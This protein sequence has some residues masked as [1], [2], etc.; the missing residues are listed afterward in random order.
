MRHYTLRFMPDDRVIQIHH[1]A[2][3]LEAAGQA[4]IV[5]TTPCG[6]M[7]RC[8]K[9]RVQL[10]R[11]GKEL[12]AC[13]T[14][15]QSDLEV[16]VPEK[17]RFLRQQILQHG[18]GRHFPLDPPVQKVFVPGRW[19]GIDAFCQK[20][21]DRGDICLHLDGP[22]EMSL[23][24]SVEDP[25]NRGA[26]G[27]GMT[28]VLFAISSEPHTQGSPKPCFRL[29][30]VEPGN[31][32]KKV[33]GAAVDIGTTT[34][35]VNLM[36]LTA[37]T[38]VATAAGANPQNRCGADVISRI[39]YAAEPSNGIELQ[40]S[41]VQCLNTLIQ[42]AAQTAGIQRESVYEIVAVGNTTMNHLLLNLPV[43]QLGQ[44]PYHA[45]SL[46]ANRKKARD[47]GLYIA[48]AG[49]LY[50]VENIA[51][52]VGS[53]TVA[54]ALAG[55]MDL[56]DGPPLLLVDIGTNGELVLRIG[57]TLWAASCAAGPSLE[58]A[59][60]LFGSSAQDGAIQRVLIDDNGDIDTDVIGG[61]PARSICGSGLIDA[62]AILLDLGIID[63]TGRFV[64]PPMILPT[65]AKP[66]AER[67]VTHEG[68]SAFRLAGRQSQRP[69]ILTQ[70]DLRQ[71]QL[72]KAAIRAGI[73]LLCRQAGLPEEDLE[74]IRLA[75][76][77][78]NY[79]RRESAVRAGLLPSIP[80]ERIRFVGNSA[81][82]GAA[83]ALTSRHARTLASQLA[84]R[85][86]YVEI[87]NH[88]QFQ[89]TF[90]ECLMFPENR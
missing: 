83:M 25:T 77:F 41:I 52:F 88:K 38:I 74:Q 61:G 75:G 55:G 32:S 42:Q 19:R 50:T 90:S 58:G 34:V 65:V 47:V 14:T 54:A 37:G 13:R 70:K 12:W 63:E 59:G 84:Q 85:I 73:R 31:T 30:T 78:G 6:G 57:Q 33:F 60:I 56:P 8:G 27:K 66:L 80:I 40:R 82:A 81:G 22:T 20:L 4:G 43:A 67:L 5:L 89:E 17:S 15:V 44:A 26:F 36:D 3:L 18:I 76:A 79:I 46:L 71:F 35:V 62:V 9:C 29:D 21:T 48:P 11:N 53:D 45:Y 1:G 16:W 24:N 2:T 7:G 69:V 49:Q 10:S 28:A 51:G 68:Q 87:A 86:T 39:Q 64:E 23:I 72:A